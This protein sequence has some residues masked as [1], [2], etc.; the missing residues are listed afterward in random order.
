LQPLLANLFSL[1]ASCWEYELFLESNHEYVPFDVMVI[2][3][4]VIAHRPFGG[5]P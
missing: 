5:L 3:V 4:I 1:C 2:V